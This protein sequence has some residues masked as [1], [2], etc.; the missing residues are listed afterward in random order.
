MFFSYSSESAS[1]GESVIEFITPPPATAAA[2]NATPLPQQDQLQT[3]LF[4]EQELTNEQ[5]YRLRLHTQAGSPGMTPVARN[6]IN[7]K[8]GEHSVSDVANVLPK[9]PPSASI[10]SKCRHVLNIGRFCRD[11]KE[12]LQR[13]YVARIWVYWGQNCLKLKLQ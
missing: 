6:L 5:P 8:A 7:L 10:P 12:A 11:V 2:R 3:R 13:S 4:K 1:K 9:P